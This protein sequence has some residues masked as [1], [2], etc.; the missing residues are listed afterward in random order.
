MPLHFGVE[1]VAFADAVFHDAVADFV[2]VADLAQRAAP[3]L[4]LLEWAKRKGKP[5]T[6]GV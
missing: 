1:R 6:W 5:V 3:L 2:A 4:E